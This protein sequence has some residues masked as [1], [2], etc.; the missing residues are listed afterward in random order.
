MKLSFLLIILLFTSIPILQAQIAGGFSQAAT[1]DAE[2][3]KAAQFAVKAHDAKLTLQYVT[4]AEQ[5]VVAGINFKL[6]LTTSDGRKA[7][8]VVWR[9]LDGSHELT[10]W[11]WIAADPAILT[12]EYIYDTGPYP[13][14][15]ATTIVETPTGLVTAWFG[16][17]A[18][19]N[20]D[21]CIWV[22]RQLPDGKWTESVETANGVQPDGSRHP[23]WNPVL[24][25]PKD[26][27]LM[28]FYKVGPS[29]STWWGELKTSTDGGKTWSA[30][31]KLPKGIFGPIKNKPVQFANG[32]ILCPTSNETD[33]KP[34]AWA[35]YFERTVDLGK[36]WTR[37]ELLHDG[38]K[39]GAI[40]PSILFLSA[41]KLE[42][43]GRTKQGKVFQITSEDVGR[44]WGEISLT[45][46]PNPNSGTDAVTLADGR[47]LLIY[48]HTAKGRSPLNLAVSKDGNT[49]EAALVFEDEPKREFSY[50]AIIQTKDGLVHITYTWKRQKVK[51]VV[52]DPAKLT[53]KPMVDGQWPQ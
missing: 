3:L 6:K 2:V 13:Q 25:Q 38:L 39:I 33:T 30:A 29:P 43:V 49:W 42:A 41:D 1:A 45:Q 44:N 32:D 37:T 46:L 15:H 52:I 11:Q 8:A 28:L 50:P 31:Q 36:T 35:I 10:S 51:H 53:T 18:E 26:A 24:F 48:N 14:I 20:P 22:S 5:Q 19:K 27:P 34:S 9:K 16:G 4:A 40:Q 12:S 23:T 17:T 47:H 7:D 21:V